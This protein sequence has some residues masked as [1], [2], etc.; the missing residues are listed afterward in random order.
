MNKT[1]HIQ[2]FALLREQRG[3]SAEELTT[4][5]ATAQELFVQLQKQYRFSLSLDLVRVAIN[6][7]FKN[8]STPIKSG[9]HIVFIPPVAGG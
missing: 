6:N 9:D 3:L 7:E 2:Y 4:G 8:W 1:V 5:A